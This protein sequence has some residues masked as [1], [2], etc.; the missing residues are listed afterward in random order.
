MFSFSEHQFPHLS[1][2]TTVPT[3]L[4][5][6]QETTHMKHGH[7]VWRTGSCLCILITSLFL[8]ALPSQNSNCKL[9]FLLRSL[10][11][12]GSPDLLVMWKM[13]QTKNVIKAHHLNPPVLYHRYFIEANSLCLKRSKYSHLKKQKPNLRQNN[14]YR[15]P[16][17]SSQL[18]L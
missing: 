10:C 9:D 5:W 6:G 15:S 7:S 8:T 12:V 11:G 16:K 13:K 4:A 14:S 1:G 2:E 3:L 18:H 17:G